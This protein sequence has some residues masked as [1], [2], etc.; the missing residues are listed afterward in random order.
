MEEALSSVMDRVVPL[1]SVQK[2]VDGSLI[3]AVLDEDVVAVEAVPG[4]RASI[5]DGYAVIG[6]VINCLLGV[7][8]WWTES[9]CW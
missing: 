1:P 5:L 7:E 4:Y 9:L 2:P 8:L 6:N 3:G